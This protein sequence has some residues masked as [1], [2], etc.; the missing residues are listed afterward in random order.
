MIHH[1]KGRWNQLLKLIKA[2]IELEQLPAFQAMK[3]MMMGF[4]SDLVARWCAGH[5][6]WNQPSLIVQR[7]D[8]AINCRHPQPRHSLLREVKNLLDC[9][10]T[11]IPLEHL[12]NFTLLLGAPAN[13]L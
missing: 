10:R 1:S 11:I 3:V 12:T 8:G 13:Y 7:L 6:H 2:P 5:F 9:E 4:A